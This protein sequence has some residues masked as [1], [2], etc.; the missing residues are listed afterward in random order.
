MRLSYPVCVLLLAVPGAALAAE[1]APAYKVGVAKVDIT[2]D[3]PIRLNGFGFRRTES[4]GVY[5]KLHARALAIEDGSKSPVVLL[6][7]DVLGIPADIHDE[8]AKRLGK[9]AGLKKDRLA[10]M[11]T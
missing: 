2:P 7:V 10:I 1:P 5:Q 4:E 8:L 3:H 9:K 11:A 6:T